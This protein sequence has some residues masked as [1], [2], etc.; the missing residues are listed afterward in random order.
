V[1]A[2]RGKERKTSLPPSASLPQKWKKVYK[3][4][5]HVTVG[6][7]PSTH[8]HRQNTSSAT[9]S[10]PLLHQPPRTPKNTQGEGQEKDVH[11]E[12]AAGERQGCDE[13]KHK[14]FFQTNPLLCFSCSLKFLVKNS[15]ASPSVFSCKSVLFEV[16]H[17]LRN[18]AGDFLGYW[19]ELSDT[20]L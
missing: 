17:A 7:S 12:Q 14:I 1:R 15:Q 18:K 19:S 2:E 3:G 16:D 9:N 11:D 6:T 13:L 20:I 4:R 10:P 8:S 5:D